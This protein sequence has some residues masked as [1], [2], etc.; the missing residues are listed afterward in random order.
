MQ[1]LQ[2]YCTKPNEITTSNEDIIQPGA[3]VQS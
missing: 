3:Y 1:F 2:F